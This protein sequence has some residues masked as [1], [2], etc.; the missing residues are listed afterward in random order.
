VFLAWG[1]YPLLLFAVFLGVGLLVEQLAGRRLSGALLAPLGMASV[2][3]VGLATT[4]FA[5]TAPL[6]APLMAVLAVAGFASAVRRRR[7]IRP[8]PWALAVGLAVFAVFA[9]PVVL[10][11]E[12][13]FAGYIKLDDT[14]TW[15][16]ITDRLLEHGRDISSL[17][18]SSYEATLY[19]N[20]AGWYPVGAFVPFGVGAKLSGQELAWVF[21]PYLALLA[22]LTAL[23]FWDLTKRIRIVP[24]LRAA[25]VFFAAQAALIFAYAMWGGI[26]ELATT[27]LLA[28]IAASA[29]RAIEEGMRSVRALLP[30]AIGAAALVGLVSF[31][32]GP[33]LL[34]LLGA[35]ALLLLRERGPAAAW[36]AAWR[37]ALLL[38][39]LIGIGLIGHPLLP[40]STKF[41]L[42]ASADLGNLAGPISPA[43]LLGI[44]PASDFRE[45]VTSPALA[46]ALMMLVALA[47]LTGAWAALRERDPGLLVALG[48]AVLG[49]ALIAIFG[50]AWVAAKSYAIVSPFAL[51][52][53]FVGLAYLARLRAGPVVAVIAALLAAGVLWSNLLGYGGVSLGPRSQLGELETIGKRF[54]GVEP[55]LMTEYQPYGVRHFLREMAPEGAS[56]LRRRTIA[57]N[58]G[59]TLEKG[60]QADIDRFA[61][62][63]VF[64]YR[65][66]V[67]RRSP[68]AS[69]PPAA[70]RLAWHGDFYDVWVRPS[71]AETPLEHLALGNELDPAAV[72]NCA[73][74]RRLAGVAAAAGGHLVAASAHHPL[75]FALGEAHR[76]GGFAPTTLGRSYLAP[77]GRAG[78]L[79][80]PVEVPVAGTYEV[81]LGGSMRPE[82]TLMVDGHE[83]GSLRQ[84][85]NTPGNY[86]D[87]GPVRLAR[88]RH[89]AS[90]R[91]GAPDLHPGSAGTDGVLGPLVLDRPD[92]SPPLHSVSPRRARNLCGK[93]WDW[94]EAVGPR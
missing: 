38:A 23:S 68:S 8:D 80:L 73:E 26:K 37:F 27:A 16:A 9:A 90:L 4:D 34:G 10:S 93:A 2:T 32:A 77:L 40:E 61:P 92:E 50:S 87:F 69:R 58:D 91:L 13:T 76:N 7:S 42:S 24:A 20:L 86:L 1:V 41:L 64:V 3:V 81:W 51:L 85:L 88:G 31:G 14:A 74:V 71:A 33:W 45:T 48:G 60:E 53:A 18:P 43:H 70:Y 30:P 52:F 94:V 25:A 44:W 19:F 79:S 82:A 49:C 83:V 66:L 62:S 65:A 15:F 5:A 63:A 17:P 59:S 35:A 29:P 22:A 54:A 46:G 28:L 78:E 55:A 6:T 72:P 56:E 21:Q 75:A 84:Q 47:A 11:G 57:L 67:L 89:L 36:G 39:P 12:S